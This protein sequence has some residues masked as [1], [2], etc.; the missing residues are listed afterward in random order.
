MWSRFRNYST[1]DSRIA[2]QIL[3]KQC[4]TLLEVR[5]RGIAHSQQCNSVVILEDHGVD[6][7]SHIWASRGGT[8][9]GIVGHEVFLSYVRF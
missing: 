9:I 7:L 3:G 6:K 8:V 4:P 2:F 5:S 1:H